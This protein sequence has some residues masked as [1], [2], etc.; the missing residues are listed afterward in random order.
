M[1]D[2]SAGVAQLRAWQQDVYLN[3]QELAA[4]PTVEQVNA[5][6]ARRVR[7]QAIA[8]GMAAASKPGADVGALMRD[9][10]QAKA[11]PLQYPSPTEYQNPN[12]YDIL[13]RIALKIAKGASVAHF[14]LPQGVTLGTLPLGSVN[15]R[16]E[17]VEGTDQ[18]VVAFQQGVFAFVHGLAKTLLLAMT[19]KDAD[20]ATFFTFD[21]DAIEKRL[22]ENAWLQE[23]FDNLLVAYLIEGN[24]WYAPTY[25]PDWFP[26]PAI[27]TPLATLLNSAEGFALSHELAHI[28]RGHFK[29]DAQRQAKAVELNMPERWYC[30]MDADLYGMVMSTATL[31]Q[32]LGAAPGEAASG[33]PLVL[34]GMDVA[35]RAQA[36]LAGCDVADASYPPLLKRR[37]S[38]YHAFA[39]NEHAREILGGAYTIDTLLE[40]LWTGAERKF[41]MLKADGAK[42]APIW[43][44]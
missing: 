3:N 19:A 22:H 28:T 44:P 29:A 8:N 34:T 38:L 36:I 39:K 26:D 33:I 32:T 25:M 42:L 23:R 9:A 11:E 17:P 1:M 13:M 15:A 21:L 7:E 30:E 43:Q 37:T 18:Y 35:Q 2:L 16:T 10:A 14:P 5:E 31:E 20:D 12:D 24:A 4:V 41:Q 40:T 6:R 27:E